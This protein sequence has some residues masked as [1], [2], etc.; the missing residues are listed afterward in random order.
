MTT[1]LDWHQNTSSVSGLRSVSHN[2][3]LF[4]VTCIVPSEPRVHCISLTCQHVHVQ[5]SDAEP[6]HSWVTQHHK[7]PPP[8]QVHPG[9]QWLVL[10]QLGDVSDVTQVQCLVTTLETAQELCLVCLV[11]GHIMIY[12]H[13]PARV[14]HSHVF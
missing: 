9:L 6:S 11:T 13:S 2:V 3:K 7:S 5:V 1:N 12:S 4:P 10:S 14:Q 8:S